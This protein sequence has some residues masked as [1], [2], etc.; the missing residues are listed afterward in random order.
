MCFTHEL[1][2]WPGFHEFWIRT[3]SSVD[4]YKSSKTDTLSLNESIGNWTCFIKCAHILYSHPWLMV[5]SRFSHSCNPMC[6]LYSIL[7][8]Y[9][10]SVSASS[11]LLLPPISMPLVAH[12]SAKDHLGHKQCK[13]MLRTHHWLLSPKEKRQRQG[14]DQDSRDT[15]LHVWCSRMLGKDHSKWFPKWLKGVMLCKYI[16]VPLG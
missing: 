14:N 1:L 11:N 10:P 3:W 15:R 8:D 6:A 7:W 4:A 16:T 13:S 9:V 12:A 2:V 5:F